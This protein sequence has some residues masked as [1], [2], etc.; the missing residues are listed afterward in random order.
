MA[1]MLVKL[2]DLPELQ[3]LLKTFKD[4]GILI[5]TALA[6]EKYDVIEWVRNSFGKQ[7]ASECDVAFSHQPV[8]CF[9]ATESGKII[10]FSCYDSTHKNFF[11]PIG[12][13][14]E[15]RGHGIGRALLLSC[16]C[17]MAANGYAY[18]IIGGADPSDF[19]AKTVRATI[20][21]GSSPGIYSD[22]LTNQVSQP[23]LTRA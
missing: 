22:Q 4:R 8:S 13:A 20:I 12:V 7:W 14:G 18:A 5:R 15:K 9:I 1:D 3:A 6:Y 21:E 10:G 19:Y 16:L 11:G 17:A 2:Y 23:L